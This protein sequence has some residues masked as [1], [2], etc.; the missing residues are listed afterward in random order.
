MAASPDSKRWFA[1]A[2]A[3]VSVVIPVLDNTILNVAIPTILREFHTELPSLQWVVTGYALTIASL[4]VIGGRLGDLYGHRRTFIVG[5]VIFA[6]GSGLGSISHSVPTLFVGEALIE[7]IGAALLFPATLSI[8]STTF[9]GAERATAFAAWGAMAGAAVAFGPFVGGFLTTT[10]SWRWALRINV[11]VAPLLAIGA[12]LFM[13]RDER[14]TGRPRL[15][16]PGAMLLSAGMFSLVFG[17][18]ESAHY[19]WWKPLRGFSVAG[20]NAWPGNRPVSIV[21]LA[22]ACA[23][24]LLTTFV[25]VERAKERR[26]RDPLF[27]FGQL[28]HLGFRYGLLTTMVLAAGQFALLF[29]LPVLLQDA[30]H[31]SALR[32]GAW[33][34]PTGV[35]I[36]LG[37]PIGGR[38]VR[39]GVNVTT[40]VRTG[41]VLEASGLVLVAA[42]ATEHASFWSLLP[43]SLAFG[44]G[45]GFASSQLTNVI[46]SD[47]APSKAGVASGANSTVRQAGWALG[48]ATFAALLNVQTIRHA[49]EGVRR[50]P[51]GASTRTQAVAE[52]HARGVNFSLRAVSPAE[53][54][55]L[56]HI[57]DHAIASGARPALLFGATIVAVGAGL[58]L[59]IPTVPSPMTATMPEPSPA[60]ELA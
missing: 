57:V 30:L 40:V 13:R 33:M 3:I 20:W 53:G 50:A 51:L 5:A 17:L 46:L 10:Y 18:S 4:L 47:I 44:L 58:S 60:P 7:G 37:A 24:V 23:G 1:A 54:S 21:P 49:I 25:F 14:P 34:L 12:W 41:L 42:A 31:L 45:V 9:T 6:I 29:V 48:I 43:G 38:L 52:L 8:L 39:R 32:T 22:F 35:M 2:I 19:G 15:D 56:R 36:A 11:I 55:T 28:E 16:A 59:L 27:E 26:G